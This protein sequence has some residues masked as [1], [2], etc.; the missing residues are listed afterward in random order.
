MKVSLSGKKGSFSVLVPGQE[1]LLRRHCQ[2]MYKQQLRIWFKQ[3]EFKAWKLVKAL[4]STAPSSIFLVTGQTLTPEYAI[5]HFEEGERSCEVVLEGTVGVPSILETKCMVGYSFERATVSAGFDVV[6]K[7]KGDDE[8]DEDWYSVFL[9][10]VPSRQMRR[11]AV[12]DRDAA[13]LLKAMQY[14][15]CPW[16][17]VDGR[18]FKDSATDQRLQDFNIVGPRPVQAE[19]STTTTVTQ[20]KPE[21]FF[22]P[23]LESTVVQ[24]RGLGANPAPS[25]SAANFVT[26]PIMDTAYVPQNLPTKPQKPALS[27]KMTQIGGGGGSIPNLPSPKTKSKS[28]VSRFFGSFSAFFKKLRFRSPIR[29][30]YLAENSTPPVSE[31]L[32]ARSWARHSAR[33]G[34]PHVSTPV[35]QNID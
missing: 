14:L 18:Y 8:D 25:A 28:N 11:L 10:V 29:R 17:C 12:G 3:V 7:K 34:Y 9:E 1:D 35:L 6:K 32:P 20:R 19:A 13:K 21:N 22:P 24:G 15:P 16:R 2:G 26:A 27:N 4:Y 5:S 30:K 31:L 23:A 33:L